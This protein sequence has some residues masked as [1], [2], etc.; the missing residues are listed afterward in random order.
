MGT[1]F[2]PWILLG[3]LCMI[4]R[5]VPHFIFCLKKAVLAPPPQPE[6]TILG[7]AALG[8]ITKVNEEKNSLKLSA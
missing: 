5:A 6:M 3:Q 2:Y 4:H 8:D 7:I 1:V